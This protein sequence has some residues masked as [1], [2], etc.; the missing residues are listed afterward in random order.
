MELKN[1][2]KS[3]KSRLI[4]ENISLSFNE[5]DIIVIVGQNGAGKSTLLSILAG[6]TKP[7]SGISN[8]DKSIISFIPQKDSLF[9]DLTVKDNLKFWSA[10]GGAKKINTTKLKITQ[11]TKKPKNNEDK[12]SENFIELLGINEYEKKKVKDLS[13]GM[14]KR[15]AICSALAQNPKIIIM[16][17]PFS[18]LD[19]FYKNELFKTIKMLN[20]L[21]KCIIY[22]S[23]NVDEIFAL[24]SKH[25]LLKDR[26]LFYMENK[27][28][29]LNHLQWG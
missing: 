28:Q 16:D 14:K 17:E 29:M 12:K 13:G 5:K 4:L 10:C 8:I 24:E 9:E 3:Y 19:M 7:D 2:S 1:I 21:G 15:V 20:G 26:K 27:E 18:G 25:Y 23:H 11:E 6:F 22:T